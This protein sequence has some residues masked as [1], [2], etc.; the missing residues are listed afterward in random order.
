MKMDELVSVSGFAGIFKI[1]TSRANGLV[2]DDLDTG[3]SKF[4]SVRKHQ[5]TPLATVAI[6]TETDTVELASVFRTM[7]DLSGETP[8]VSVNESKENIESYFKKII[9]DYDR[10]KVYISDMKKV[11]KWFNFLNE[12]KLLESALASSEEE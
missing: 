10:D 5:F 9:P 6:Y 4:C 1:N 12:R 11:V 3:K 2:V 8:V 7:L